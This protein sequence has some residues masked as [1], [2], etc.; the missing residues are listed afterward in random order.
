MRVVLH[1]ILDKL[2]LNIITSRFYIREAREVLV[3]V[4]LLYINSTKNKKNK[5]YSR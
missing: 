2:T 4:M 3:Q 5:G 1:F